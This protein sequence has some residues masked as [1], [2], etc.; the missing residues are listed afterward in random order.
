MKP[1]SVDPGEASGPYCS[2]AHKKFGEQ[3][4]ISC[5][6]GSRTRLDA[7]CRPC[8][9]KAVITAPMIITVPEDHQS[10]WSIEKQFLQSWKHNTP[11]PDVRAIYKIV[12]T[13]ERLGKYRQYQDTVE[14]QGKFVNMGKLRGN[15]KRRWHGTRRK[16]LLGDPGNTELCMDPRCLLCCIIRT[17]FDLKF[18]KKGKFGAGIY[19]LSAS[20]KSD[21]YSKNLN[22]H[23]NWKALLLNDVVIG[24]SKK[25]AQRSEMSSGVPSGYNSV[26]VKMN[27][28]AVNYDTIFV[29]NEDAIR[30]SYLVM[31]ESP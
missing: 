3:G 16:C 6:A 2:V 28:S 30:P 7:L 9:V 14:A 13:E 12:N 17:S 21:E 26:T 29:Y 22:I 31:Y 4:C 23:S 25:L 10:F 18:Y 5:R 19:A 20:S 11:C 24:N 27:L 8:Y 15:E 1:V